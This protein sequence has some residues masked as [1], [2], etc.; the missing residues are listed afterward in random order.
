MLLIPTDSVPATIL[1]H[2]ILPHIALLLDLDLVI[3]LILFLVVA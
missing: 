2:L 3:L 1:H